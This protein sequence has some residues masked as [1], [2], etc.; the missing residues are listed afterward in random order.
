MSAWQERWCGTGK[1][2][3][4]LLLFH[5][6]EEATEPI[7]HELIREISFH[8]PSPCNKFDTVN[9][10]YY[11]QKHNRAGQNIIFF[12]IDTRVSIRPEIWTFTFTLNCI[13]PIVY[14]LCEYLFIYLLKILPFRSLNSSIVFMLDP[15]CLSK[16]YFL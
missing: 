4:P 2:D 3:V 14:L 8:K 12:Q 6:W 7:K 1:K 11:Q 15:I 9:Q 10:L 13:T 16:H 5:F